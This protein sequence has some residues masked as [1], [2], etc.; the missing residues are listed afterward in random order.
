MATRR[1]Y[2]SENGESGSIDKYGVVSLAVPFYV[3]G[4]AEAI[5]GSL[6]NDTSLGENIGKRR[7]NPWAG[8][9]GYIVLATFEGCDASLLDREDKFF[10]E[11]DSSFAERRL[12]SHPKIKDLIT[13]YGGQVQ[14]D[15]TIFWP[16]TYSA[17]SNSG[18]GFGGT[19]VAAKNP[20]FGADSYVELQAVFRMT[21]IRSSPSRD[22]VERIGTIKKDLPVSVATPSGRDWLVMPPKVSERGNVIT[23]QDEWLLGPPGGWPADIYELLVK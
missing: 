23:E 2:G 12:E 19:A 1:L 7:F 16:L 13:K 17:T 22:L 5:A 15:G 11:F 4:L 6:P 8:G 14:D 21:K 10:W 18:T 3:D 20:L 9:S